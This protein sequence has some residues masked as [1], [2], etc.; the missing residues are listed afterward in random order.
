M[1]SSTPLH[2]QTA[3]TSRSRSA[4]AMHDSA[5]ARSQA[6]SRE[7]APFVRSRSAP[8][9]RDTPAA[10]QEPSVPKDG[11]PPNLRERFGH[12]LVLT[13]GWGAAGLTTL[14]FGT[15]GGAIGQVVG[16]QTAGQ[17]LGVGLAYPLARHINSS[18]RALANNWF[19]GGQWGSNATAHR[20]EAHDL[21][22]IV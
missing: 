14:A 18:A 21:V 17:T 10:S 8:A 3:P 6:P 13:T 22:R 12:H 2:V 5:T 20:P 4:S 1:R 19:P 15:A 16:Q 7:P 9:P 11:L